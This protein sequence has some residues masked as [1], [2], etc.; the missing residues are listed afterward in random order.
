MKMHASSMYGSLQ[1]FQFLGGSHMTDS[2][3]SL[4]MAY[5]AR[6]IAMVLLILVK[7]LSINVFTNIFI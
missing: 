7:L 5:L 3:V 1:C 6:H 4:K 2:I